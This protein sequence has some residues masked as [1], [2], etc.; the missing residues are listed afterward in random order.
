MAISIFFLTYFLINCILKP[1]NDESRIVIRLSRSL[2]VLLPIS[3]LCSIA[4]I[5]FLSPLDSLYLPWLQ[6]PANTYL[7][8]ILSLFVL[9]F[10][11]GYFILDLS[12]RKKRFSTPEKLVF[13]CLISILLDCLLV[14]FLQI[15]TGA[16]ISDIIFVPIAIFSVLSI[17]KSLKSFREQPSTSSTLPIQKSSSSILLILTLVFVF[18]GIYSLYARSPSLLNDLVPL[19]GWAVMT[20]R[21]VISSN[22]SLFST[23]LSIFF[24]ISGLPT[25]NAYVLLS[26][27]TILLPIAFYMM[28]TAL[29]RSKRAASVATALF[30]TCSG[31]AGVLVIKDYLTLNITDEFARQALLNTINMQTMLDMRYAYYTS[32]FFFTHMLWGLVPVFLSIYLFKKNNECLLTYVLIAILTDFG[33]LAHRVEITIFFVFLLATIWVISKP[34]S[35]SHYRKSIIASVSGVIVGFVT[36]C[37]TPNGLAYESVDFYFIGFIIG[38]SIVSYLLTLSQRRLVFSKNIFKNK[39]FLLAIIFLIIYFV[40]LSLITWASMQNELVLNFQEYYNRGII[41]WFNYPLFWGATGLIAVL[42]IPYILLHKRENTSN[43]NLYSIL[44]VVLF[45]V[46]FGFLISQF[47]VHLS[48]PLP[49][50]EARTIY[51]VRIFAAILAAV[52]LIRLARYLSPNV[53]SI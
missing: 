31:F 27:S 53:A 29:T 39:A 36:F 23:Y 5:L 38:I 37:L 21:N 14:Y 32:Y 26:F 28:A 49:F 19:H 40:G 48:T 7:R 12:D 25:V 13:G 51:W 4:L 24:S 3:L 6:I 11:P 45:S 2:G 41:P 8:A 20:L 46:I 17:I 42:A 44:L 34:Q 10:F 52:I 50:W 16:F 35:M 43:N 22:L 30:I 15:I 1:S 33:Y 47:N 18:V 9:S